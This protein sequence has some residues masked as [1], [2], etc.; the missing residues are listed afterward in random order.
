MPASGE[1]RA[2]LSSVTA[3][4]RRSPSEGSEERS[5]GRD[6]GAASAAWEAEEPRP[7]A[8]G[9]PTLT[10]A[11]TPRETPKEKSL[12][13]RACS[14][15]R[16]MRLSRL[17]AHA[18]PRLPRPAWTSPLSEAKRG[19]PEPFHRGSAGTAQKA[20]CQAEFKAENCNIY[21]ILSL[22]RAT[23]GIQ[24]VFHRAPTDASPCA[25]GAVP[26]PCQVGG[27]ELPLAA[28]KAPRRE[29]RQTRR[30][31]RTGKVGFRDTDLDSEAAG[32]LREP[33]PRPL[34]G[35][36]HGA[37]PPWDL[38]LG[39]T[40]VEAGPGPEGEDERPWR[41]IRP[42]WGGA[43]CAPWRLL[44]GSPGLPALELLYFEP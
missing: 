27:S 9:S 23:L 8:A 36:C 18:S 22:S 10:D 5:K 37:I 33:G 44:R 28:S 24:S 43:L 4:A 26:K 19:D 41:H 25:A 11:Q 21:L 42:E 16:S 34:R 13:H 15:L 35:P 3:H 1:R 14:S 38:S 20:D 6:M 2:N 30:P 29:P 39:V 12:G 7:P 17:S 31:M 40:L 32:G